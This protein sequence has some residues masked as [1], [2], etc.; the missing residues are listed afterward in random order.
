MKKSIA[1][2]LV[3]IFMLAFVSCKDKQNE[4]PK[5]PTDSLLDFFSE[6]SDDYRAG[7]REEQFM[8]P[9]DETAVMLASKIDYYLDHVNCKNI[10]PDFDNIT[11]VTDAEPFL[12]LAKFRTPS[13]DLNKL[14]DYP[15]NPVTKLAQKLR[16][17]GNDIENIWYK[18]DILETLVRLFGENAKNN[19]NFAKFTGNLIFSTYFPDEEVY[20]M[21]GAIGGNSAIPQVVS[22]EKTEVGYVC[23][24]FIYSSYAVVPWQDAPVLVKKDYEN[25]PDKYPLYRYTFDDNMILTKFEIIRNADISQYGISN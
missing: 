15:D 7:G 10:M 5:I 9:N 20:I 18:S 25:N 24:A 3:L 2:F 11:K 23:E 19:K 13:I 17:E 4:T 1:L 22:Y 12:N 21:L 8:M 16:E 14:A 6:H